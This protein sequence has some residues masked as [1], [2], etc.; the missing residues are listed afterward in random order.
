M[1]RARDDD[2]S[3]AAGYLDAWRRARREY[4]GARAV[5]PRGK[6]RASI[7]RVRG[8]CRGAIARWDGKMLKIL[9]FW[10]EARVTARGGADVEAKRTNR[11]TDDGERAENEQ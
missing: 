4:V 11:K 7:L 1:G 9:D 5:I 6:S 2:P 3:A 8:G 10:D